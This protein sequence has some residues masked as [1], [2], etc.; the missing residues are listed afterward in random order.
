MPSR[1]VFSNKIKKKLL[2]PF[3]NILLF[4]LLTKNIV[5]IYPFFPGKIL[6]LKLFNF[7]QKV[8]RIVDIDIVPLIFG[9]FAVRHNDTIFFFLFDF[10][11]ESVGL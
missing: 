3:I 10:S 9:T 2:L 8:R 4:Y 6:P 7:K 11:K 5:D 1:D